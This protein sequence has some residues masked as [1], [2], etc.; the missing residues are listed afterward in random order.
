MHDN[1]L[2]QHDDVEQ[3]DKFKCKEQTYTTNKTKQNDTRQIK[4]ELNTKDT[5]CVGNQ[6]ATTNEA[7]AQKILFC[8]KAF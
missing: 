7:I 6:D 2:K 1:F 5:R 8:N 4:R 3:N